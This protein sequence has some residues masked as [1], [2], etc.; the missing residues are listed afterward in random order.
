MTRPRVARGLVPDHH[1]HERG[2]TRLTPRSHPMAA[3]HDAIG[4]RGVLH[5]FQKATSAAPLSVQRR[6]SHGLSRQGGSTDRGLLRGLGA[7]QPIDH[8]VRSHTEAG[9]GIGLSD[10]RIHTDP[11]AAQ[12]ARHL[13]AD[14]FAVGQDIYFGSGRYRPDT[15]GGRHLLAHEIVHTAQQRGA[16]AAGPQASLTI[17]GANDSLEQEAEATARQV[18]EIEPPSAGGPPIAPGGTALSIQR[19]P[20]SGALHADA[21]PRAYQPAVSARDVAA[22]GPA[23]AGWDKRFGQRIIP[24]DPTVSDLEER[25]AERLKFNPGGKQLDGV[26][27]AQAWTSDLSGFEAAERQRYRIDQLTETMMTELPAELWLPTNA[28]MQR[29]LY[30]NAQVQAIES[31]RQVDPT[32]IR[33]KLLTRLKAL[34]GDKIDPLAP[35]EPIWSETLGDMVPGA[36]NKA[37]FTD[38]ENLILWFLFPNEMR[39]W[40]RREVAVQESVQQEHERRGGVVTGAVAGGA[41]QLIAVGSIPVLLAAAV[42][43]LPAAAAVATEASA[44]GAAMSNFA[45]STGLRMAP[46]AIAWALA[47]PQTAIT[48]TAVGANVGHDIWT[49]DF[50]ALNIPFYA[51]E[52]WGA[53]LG[54]R[55]TPG[56]SYPT[57]EP[58]EPSEQ[59]LVRPPGGSETAH[60]DLVIDHPQ[61]DRATRTVSQTVRS[62]NGRGTLRGENNI[63][64]GRKTITNLAAGEVTVVDPGIEAPALG[65]GR[66]AD[67]PQ[68]TGPGNA[69]MIDASEPPSAQRETGIAAIKGV[70]TDRGPGGSSAT[71]LFGKGPRPQLRLGAP[72]YEDFAEPGQQLTQPPAPKP[73]TPVVTKLPRSSAPLSGAV[74]SADPH[75]PAPSVTQPMK[76]LP[77]GAPRS[78]VTVTATTITPAKRS[79]PVVTTL[80]RSSEPWSDPNQLPSVQRNTYPDFEP[81]TPTLQKNAH[82]QTAK[83][84]AQLKGLNIPEDRVLSAPWIGRIRNRTGKIQS[85]STSEGWLRNESRFWSEWKR[86]F[87]DDAKLLGPNNTVT[88][89]LADKY[90][91]P[92]SGADSVVGQKLVH[93]HIDNGVLTVALPEKVHQKLS[94]EIHATPTVVGAP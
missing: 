37:P 11:G 77:G 1:V 35:A 22:F 40:A 25:Q 62:L 75:A 16:G 63:A 80:P 88:E 49:G 33:S 19:Q 48:V 74:Y 91:W 28:D 9:L 93:H 34:R 64:T 3:L 21:P 6:P 94:G 42:L 47:N 90:G 69:L 68:P 10:V 51:A 7:G 43:G 26:E 78:T 8:G 32:P 92:T 70:A 20:D 2:R 57:G 29:S 15:Q 54:D 72:Q 79:T 13:R 84:S 65:P 61:S 31:G 46:R 58:D 5:A 50:S 52:I 41:L 60:P 82:A 86:Q 18:T 73:A 89:A 59:A 56:S 45:L 67:K 76:R 23:P 71:P 44:A 81:V 87:P 4:N 36:I 14:A 38:E 39:E 12:A 27:L 17:P 66:V 55:A 83:L 30:R 85:S 53:R 24:P